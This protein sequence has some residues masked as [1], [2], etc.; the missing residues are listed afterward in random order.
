MA[1]SP[2]QPSRCLSHVRLRTASGASR[3]ADVRVYDEK[4]TLLA[5]I[6]DVQLQPV[7]AGALSRLGARWLD[8][9]LYEWAWRRV[10]ASDTA[11]EPSPAQ[12]AEAAQSHVGDHR[13]A[14]GLD[15]YDIF[16]PRFDAWCAMQVVRTMRELGWLPR[17][18]ERVAG[19]QALAD[20]LG[21]A[22]RHR[23]L[24]A[25]L[26]AILVEEGWL[27]RQGEGYVVQSA[28]P[29]PDVTDGAPA[30]LL[31]ACPAARAE[32]ELTERVTRDLAPALRGQRDAADLLFPAGSLDTT[33]RLYRDSP[34]ARFYNSVIAD[35]IAAATQRPRARPLRIIELGAGTG[36]TTAHVL[37]RVATAGVE[38]TYTDIGAL[39]VARAKERFAPHARFMRFA[40][41][42]LELA[43]QEQGFDVGSYD[44]VIASNVVHATTDI[45]RT[46]GHAR[47]LLAEGGLLVMLEVTAPQ[48]WF[49]LTV[50]LTDGWWAFTDIALRPDYPALARTAWLELLPRCG[51]VDAAALPPAG[52]P[53]VLG[54]QSVFVARAGAQSDPE[55]SGSP[56]W[57]VLADSG[58]AGDG[59]VRALRSRGDH[60]VQVSIDRSTSP[61]EALRQLRLQR[62]PLRGAIHAASL[63]DMPADALD[64]DALQTRQ[65][66]GV[67]AALSLAQALLTAGDVP[68]RLWLVT[69]A[70]V[71][72]DAVDASVDATQAPLWGLGKALALEHPELRCVCIDVDDLQ[73]S[74]AALLRELDE[75]GDESQVALRH[76]ERLV[77]RLVPMQR[78]VHPLNEPAAWRLVAAV[79][80]S[81]DRF[82]RV[83]MTRRAPQAGE[84][85][86]AV[87]A[88]GLN[89][90]D[91]L[92]ALDLYPGDAGPLG[93][94]CAGI[95]VSVGAGVAELQVGDAVLAV[96]AGSFASHVVAKAHLVRKLPPGVPFEEG[97]TFAIAYLTAGFCLH[98][99]ARLTSGRRVLVHAAAGGVG[100]AAVHL[101]LRTGAEV[102]ATAGSPA[103]RE[104]LRALGV[105]HVF[106]SRSAAFGERVLAQTA[107]AGVDVVLNSLAGDALIEA[108]FAALS[109]GGHFVE[110]GKRGIKTADWVQ[111]LGRDIRYHVVDWGETEVRDPALVSGLLDD[112]MAAWRRGELP[113]LP[114]HA[115]TLGPAAEGAASA[116]RLMAQARHIGR[117]VLRRRDPSSPPVRRDGTYLVT[118]GL[119]GL[120]LIVAGW[121]VEQSAGRVVLIGRRGVTSEAAPLLAAWRARG[122]QIA[123]HALDVADPAALGTLLQDL[124]RDGPP[125]RGLIHSAGEVA[126]GSVLQQ[127]A[128]QFARG[129]RAKVQGAHALEAATR[130]D[131]LDFFVLFSSVASVLGSAGQ[132]NHCAANAFL[133]QFAQARHLRGLPAVAIN[134]G[135]WTDVGAAVKGGVAE[136]MASMGLAPITPAQGLQALERALAW[137]LAQ[138]IVLPA[139]WARYAAKV[140]RNGHAPAWLGELLAAAPSPSSTHWTTSPRAANSTIEQGDAARGANGIQAQILAA[141]V[142][143]RRTLLATFVR[144]RALRALGQL[145]G[146]GIDP[147]VPLGEL[148]LDS[149]LAVELRNTLATALGRPLPATLL[150]DHPTI[151]ALTDHLLRELS[152]PDTPQ[153]EVTG[154][155]IG[156]S[157]STIVDCIE[158]L[159]DEEVERQL[160]ARS[161]SKAQ[162]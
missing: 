36:G 30:A 123:V 132:S 133:D 162:R 22:G 143:R 4:G 64:A 151:D 157:A 135:A 3:R 66:R 116:W 51:F 61:A 90:K 103:K 106:D 148:G 77:A 114:R 100:L 99:L 137:P 65:Q 72:A 158:D 130:A 104:L 31:A 1:T 93:S 136:R 56:A 126:D 47:S 109:H 120:G 141:P 41:L 48:R 83:P 14:A 115:F 26:L 69:R 124:R 35:V 121:L 131:A 21:V 25:R 18:G 27:T 67:L 49:D 13:V 82:D 122:A 34:T 101:A 119:G 81:L 50:G 85:E 62:R 73:S 125:L 89:F 147:S 108:S 53:G 45:E 58:S 80:G 111:K 149:L 5:E 19:A 57:L 78:P 138:M 140:M 161:Q 24:F 59:L 71:R 11:L 102:Y 23:R 46:L 75:G 129:F 110:M 86:I 55:R 15:L 134:W 145:A 28:W 139:A 118:G 8:A 37:P 105:A 32:V 146:H 2:Q 94:E 9:A 70:A 128:E 10:P 39:F 79:P 92:N 17:A 155:S 43:P 95:V 40:T 87:E 156:S 113:P 38:Y 7:D 97:A 150:F 68:P 112:L 117:V 29:V 159:S 144:E 127:D 44:V 98:H 16:L 160:S 42:N 76:G 84:V 63:D 33:E 152:T 54:L 107:G 88:A 20:A 154:R 52:Q 6:D 96:A 12:L 153:L 60:V 74:Q 91:V 142:G